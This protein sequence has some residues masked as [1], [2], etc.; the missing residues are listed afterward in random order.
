M[1]RTAAALR[2]AAALVAAQAVGLGALVVFYVVE[3]LVATTTNAAAAVTTIV[4]V[5][6]AAAGVAL[7]ARGLQQRRRWARSPVLVLQLV[8]LPVAIGLVQG[9]IWYVGIPLALWAVAV[10]VLL[11]SPG[12]NAALAGPEPVEG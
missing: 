5:A 2:A 8:A 7:C 12:S 10:V 6:L 9:G 3:L 11:Y 4:L 1:L